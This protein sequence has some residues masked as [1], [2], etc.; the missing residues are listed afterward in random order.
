MGGCGPKF[1]W[2]RARTSPRAVR[3]WKPRSCP[4]PELSA[5]R[6]QSEVRT[7][8]GHRSLR[9]WD[10][11][12]RLESRFVIDSVVLT[13]LESFGG[14]VSKSTPKFLSITKGRRPLA[15]SGGKTRRRGEDTQDDVLG[16]GV[17]AA[18]TLLWAVLLLSQLRGNR[19]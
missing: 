2:K 3:P 16:P 4:A 7:S 5:R 17:H 9:K 18:G 8:Q 10:V 12:K 14:T 6:C 15:P 11:A 1:F 19:P 13:L